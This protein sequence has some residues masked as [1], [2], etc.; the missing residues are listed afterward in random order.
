[1]IMKDSTSFE[2][3][4]KNP[5]DIVGKL[6]RQKDLSDEELLCLI[7]S[8]EYDEELFEKADK[9]RRE[10]YKDEVYLRGLIEFTNYCK[11][12]CYYCGIR[13][14]N[15]SVKRYRMTFD[16]II[17]AC[18]QGYQLGY[19]TFV[20]QGGEDP[21]YTDERI[22]RIVSEIRR[23][24]PKC[25]ITLSLGEKSKESYQAYF[26]AGANRYLLRHE[27]ASDLHYRKLHPEEMKLEN[28]K[29]CLFDLKEIGYQV[30]AGFMVESPFQKATDLISDLRFLQELEPDMIGIGPFISHSDTPF[31][32]YKNGSLELSLRMIAILRLMFPYAL[33]PA[34][35]ALGTI[36]PQGREQGLKAGANVVMPNLTPSGVRENYLLY[37]NKIC[38]GDEPGMCRGC[39]ERR[40]N[41]A[42]YQVVVGI[43][44]VSNIE[45]NGENENGKK[46][47]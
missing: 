24:F 28:R 44:N 29:H 4:S 26:D 20:L 27:T 8:R 35:T 37:D 30:G 39:I 1:M 22:C 31:H 2:S 25:A 13:R 14:S 32:E 42:G 7:Q 11:N 17:S 46:R 15:Q 38:T 16:E 10:F 36:H 19:H 12:D 41:K 9:R 47:K 34:T 43:G 40:V 23:R 5:Y 6:Y 33:I 21:Y 3:A 18:E 45:E